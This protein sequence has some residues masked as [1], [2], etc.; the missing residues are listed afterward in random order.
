M[1]ARRTV[2]QAMTIARLKEL[3]EKATP[4]EW[5]NRDT[6]G[7]KHPAVYVERDDGLTI[8]RIN[9][10]DVTCTI[11]KYEHELDNAALI[12]ALHNAAP[13]LIAAAEALQEILS[14]GGLNSENAKCARAALRA[15]EKS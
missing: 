11:G 2:L 5:R 15:I 14:D 4:G 12:A 6:T 3:M 1:R 10:L 7:W 13:A 9:I 8:A